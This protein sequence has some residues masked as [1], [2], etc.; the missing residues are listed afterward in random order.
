MI[1]AINT[2]LT[3]RTELSEGARAALAGM[4]E[5]HDW[6]KVAERTREAYDRVVRP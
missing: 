6:Q 5:R 3:E 4:R 1:R 2:A